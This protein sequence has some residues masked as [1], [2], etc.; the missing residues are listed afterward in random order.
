MNVI[1]GDVRGVQSS[2]CAGVV[3][4]GAH[5]DAHWG[6]SVQL[7]RVPDE[8]RVRLV[9]GATYADTY[10]RTPLHL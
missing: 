7:Q 1:T 10:R 2:V 3:L 5:E 8:V 6:P 9:A 4:E